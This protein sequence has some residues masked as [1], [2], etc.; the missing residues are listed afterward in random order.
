MACVDGAGLRA[1]SCEERRVR[2]IH[3]ASRPGGL[4]TR[5]TSRG[6]PSFGRRALTGSHWASHKV[7]SFVKGESACSTPANWHSYITGFIAA[8]ACSAV[9]HRMWSWS[10]GVALVTAT[11]ALGWH[12]VA[13]D[14]WMR[15]R[16]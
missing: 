16:E 8:R 2:S 15:L 10:G 4:T 1:C 7:R 9:Y 14:K 11:P 12:L 5:F 6:V 3:P 13:A